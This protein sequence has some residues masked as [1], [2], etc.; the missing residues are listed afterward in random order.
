[1]TD[2]PRWHN[3]HRHQAYGLNCD[4]YV[5][6]VEYTGNRCQLCSVPAQAMFHGKL[7]ID[8][9][10][11]LGM[12]AIRGLLCNHCNSLM[13]EGYAPPQG[14]DAYLTD[15]WYRRLLARAGV[16]DQLA[17]P[18]PDAVVQVRGR[19]FHKVDDLWR[20]MQRGLVDS[21]PWA[22]LHYRFGPRSIKIA[23]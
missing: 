20:P 10:G 19:R 22:R 15:P 14:G 1:M 7:H 16:P 21:Y 9:D 8:H 11:R 6:V 17:E 4:E 12:W 2:A 3:T 13:Q 23:A 18:E 5:E